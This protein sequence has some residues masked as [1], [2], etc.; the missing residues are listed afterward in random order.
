MAELEDEF[1]RKAQFKPYL[2]WRYIDDIFFLWQ[3]GEEKLKSFIDNINKMH[4]TIKFTADWS[5][6]SINF[7]DVTVSIAEGVI[8]T[9]LYVK[10]TYRHQYLLSSSCHPFYRKKG[11]PYSQVLRL[12]RISSNNEFFDKRFNGLDKYLL[13]KGYSEK[14]VRKEILQTRAIPR[15]ALLEKVNNQEKQNKI[16]FN[17][18]CHPVFGDVRKIF[19]E[20]HVILASDDGH[21]KVFPEVPMIGF[22]NNKNLKAHLVRSQLP[23]LD[24]VG[25]SK[26]CGGKRPPCHL[27]EN[28]KDT[29]TFKSKHLNE[30]HKINKKYNCNSKMAVYLIECESNVVSNILTVQKQSLDLGQITMSTQNKR[31]HEHY[32]SD[33]H[34]DIQ[35]WVITLIDSTDTLKELRRKE[36]YWMYKL[37]TFAPYNL[38]ES[39]VYEAL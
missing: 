2:W 10:P 6:T 33:R 35:D 9:D 11:V 4:P 20:L 23:D 32:C 27:C 14:M 28:M 16:T 34:N 17:I 36:L 25:R 26:P 5:K 31:F 3:L 38:K 1:L 7:L 37:K 18:A 21:K 22:K 15:D 39:D 24:E 13:E 30:V 12:N 8:E 19:E 29:C